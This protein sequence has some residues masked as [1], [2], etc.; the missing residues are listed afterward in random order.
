MSRR[1]FNSAERVALWL[2]ADGRCQSCGIEL[3]PGWHADHVNP[4]SKG[5]PTDVINGAAL[6]PSC[7]MKKG[8]TSM[9]ISQLRAWQKDALEKFLSTDRDFLVE[10]T[11]GAGKTRMALAAA[12]ELISSG[13]IRR[14]IVVVPSVNLQSQW[15]RAAA[16]SG[17]DVTGTMKN[18]DG[19]IAAAKHGAVVTY[20]QVASQPDLWRHIT[21]QAATLVVLDEI[22]HAGDEENST[23]GAAL[24]TA[25]AVAP[26]RLML[27]GTP[28]R[29]DGA[30]IPFVRYDD[31]GYAISDEGLTYG[32]A[33]RDGVVRPVRYEI[34]DGRAD[35]IDFGTQV[36]VNLSEAKQKDIPDALKVLYD[37]RQEWIPSV[38]RRAN[39]EL[40]RARE[41][42]PDAGGLVLA[43]SQWHAEQYG[44]IMT[45]ISGEQTTV[46]HSTVEDA[47]AQL[48]AFSAGSDRWMVAV[49]M[50]SEGVDIP[51]LAVGVY[52]SRDMTEMW[53]RQVTGRFV[54][55]RGDEDYMTAT[56][57]I[58]H[59]KVLMDLAERIE[60][61]AQVALREAEQ[62][63]ID[64]AD[65]EE[66]TLELSFIE[67]LA[68]SESVLTGAIAAGEAISDAELERAKEYI[69]RIGGSMRAV[70]PVDAVKLL[71][72]ANPTAPTVQ[73]VVRIPPSDVTGDQLR[74]SLRRQ[75]SAL[76]GR[77]AYATEQPH[78]HIHAQLNRMYGGKVATA[79]VDELRKRITSVEEWI[80]AY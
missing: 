50:V 71:R 6:C 19:S 16:E 18:A 49:K 77:Y 58:P 44:R 47:G 41:E 3:Q 28:F 80:E 75:L 14:I 66:R 27:S 61:E 24:R 40:T 17:L 67:P 52:A 56:I 76:V 70:H 64:R 65:R 10:A 72:L 8:D 60:Q 43:P 37:P 74:Q 7:N 69:E 78:S 11:P 12:H 73:T 59:V 31:Q 46:I 54:R 21:A 32:E 35:W 13:H 5:G 38:F 55:V 79:T 26:R 48:R 1:R 15:S 20:P 53:F 68:A 29:T 51:R 9:S 33:V 42:M 45:A 62:E 39:D 57:F 30:P 4:Y 34:L 22:H 63:A 23:W 2:A 36:S 25:F